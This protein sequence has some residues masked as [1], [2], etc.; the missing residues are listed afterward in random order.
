MGY[1]ELH[2]FDGAVRP[3]DGTIQQDPVRAPGS[4]ADRLRAGSSGARASIRVVPTDICGSADAPPI[5]FAECA[6]DRDCGTGF[7]CMGGECLDRCN[8]A[9]DLAPAQVG[10]FTAWVDEDDRSWE[11]ATF[12]FDVPDS[13]RG[14]FG[15]EVRISREPFVPGEDFRAWGY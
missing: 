10:G 15:Y 1:G 9:I 4:G 5:C 11:F 12:A 6:E 3:L 14:L 2:G 8:S 13:Q 7:L